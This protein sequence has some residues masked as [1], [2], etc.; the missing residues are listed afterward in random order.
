MAS[1]SSSN[2]SCKT[3]ILAD[4]CIAVH[5]IQMRRRGS[6]ALSYELELAEK[7]FPIQQMGDR[8]GYRVGRLCIAKAHCKS[9]TPSSRNRITNLFRRKDETC[10]ASSGKRN[11]ICRAVPR[12]YLLGTTTSARSCFC[13]AYREAKD[14]KMEAEVCFMT[15]TFLLQVL[16]HSPEKLGDITHLIL[17][18]MH[19]R[20]SCEIVLYSYCHHALQILF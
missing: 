10:N 2:L 1:Q 14:N 3:G 13:T 18:E 9:I 20:L 12:F 5:A 7:M 19:D 8:I 17:D 15:S 16:M 4:T 11:R 6:C